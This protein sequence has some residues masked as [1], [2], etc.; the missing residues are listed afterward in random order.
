[1]GLEGGGAGR[2][3]DGGEGRRWCIKGVVRLQATLITGIGRFANNKRC[4][5]IRDGGYN[6]AHEQD[7]SVVSAGWSLMGT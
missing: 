2:V 5:V 3:I 7:R 6:R 4:L 1:M